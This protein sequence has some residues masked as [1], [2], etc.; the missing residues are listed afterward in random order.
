M[1]RVVSV[2]IDLFVLGGRINLAALIKELL[3]DLVH[4]KIVHHD[5][6]KLV[7][8]GHSVAWE[9][10]PGWEEHCNTKCDIQV[11]LKS[12]YSMGA[13]DRRDILILSKF[14]SGYSI[15]ELSINAPDCRERLISTLALLEDATRYTD[16]R[17]LER[18]ITKYP[19]YKETKEAYRNKLIEAGRTFD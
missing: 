8:S 11:S 13:V 15:A 6:A 12:L 14:M 9:Y 3:T 17:F 7:E 10:L 4:N 5:V 1:I 19:K 2:A 18:V 16:D